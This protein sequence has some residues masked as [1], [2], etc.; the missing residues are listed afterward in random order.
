MSQPDTNYTVLLE[1]PTTATVLAVSGKTVTGF[2]VNASVAFSGTV[3]LS[4]V[5]GQ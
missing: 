2:N 5:R 3:G 4:I 1:C